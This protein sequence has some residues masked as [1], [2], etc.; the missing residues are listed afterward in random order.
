V[1]VFAVLFGWLGLD[2]K[3]TLLQSGGM[4]LVFAGVSLSSVDVKWQKLET[5]SV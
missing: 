2:E 4:L 3:L 5:D 1:S